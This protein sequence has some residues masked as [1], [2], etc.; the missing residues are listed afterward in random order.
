MT[1]NKPPAAILELNQEQAELMMTN[2]NSN[3]TLGLQ[4]LNGV[5]SRENAEKLVKFNE[6]FKTIRAS[7][8]NQGI[9]ERN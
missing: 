6:F 2:C 3:L 7:L 8:L 5:K 1:T 9:K 4:L